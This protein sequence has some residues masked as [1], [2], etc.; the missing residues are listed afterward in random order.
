[1]NHYLIKQSIQGAGRPKIP[2]PEP[3]PPAE[4]QP[5]KLGKMQSLAS[6]SYAETI[7]LVSDGP[8]EGLVNQNGQYV[9]GHRIFEAIYFDEVPV[10]KSLDI[11]FTGTNSVTRADYSLTGAATNLYKLWFWPG[12]FNEKSF[13]GV[14]DF[15]ATGNYNTGTFQTGGAYSFVKERSYFTTNSQVNDPYTCL[16]YA[17][18]YFVGNTGNLFACP[19]P[20]LRESQFEITWTRNDIAK[21]IYRSIDTINEVAARASTYGS[22]ASITAKAKQLRYNFESWVDVKD[23]LLP[24]YIDS[25]ENDYPIFAVK[26][27]LGEPYDDTI[28]G[29]CGTAIIK[30][31]SNPKDITVSSDFTVDEFT[32]SVLIDDI[33]NQVFQKIEIEDISTAR[34]LR[35]LSYLDLT[36]VTKTSSTNLQ[37]AGS[38]IVF[39]FKRDGVSPTQESIQAIKDFVSQVSVINF[40][41][42]KYNYNNVLAEFRDGGELQAPLSYFDK[43]YLSK[44]ISTKLVGPFDVS[45]NVFRISKFDDDTGFNIGESYEFPLQ[46]AQANEGSTDIRTNKNFSSYAGNGKTSFVE[47]AI[48]ITHFVENPNVDRVVVTIGVRGLSDTVQIDSS[49]AGLGSVQAGTKVPS[50]VRFKL[51][52]GLQDSSGKDVTSSVEERIYQIVGLAD[53]PLLVDIGRAE[54]SSII[55]KYKFLAATKSNT[56]IDASTPIVLPTSTNGQRRF[57]RLT[58]TTY[59][60]SSVLMRREISLEKVTEIISSAFSYPTSAI[61][62]TK[63]DSRNISQIPPRSF[64]LRL[65]RV[66]VPSNYYPLRPDGRDKRRYRTLDD[67]NQASA[68]DLLIYKGNWDGT[69]KEAW[70]DNPAWVLFD[71]LIDTEY[72]LG[73]FVS[74]EQVNIWELYKI[75]RF[76]DAVDANGVFVGVPNQFGGKEPRYSINIILGDKVDVYQTINS[77]ANAFRGNIFYSNSEINF[78]DDR[79]KLPVYEFS[80]TNVKEGTFTYTNARR[81]QEYNVVE[82]AYLDENDD[83]KAKVEYVE[84]PE[85]IRQRGVLRTNIDSFGITSKTSANRIGQ[86]ILQ[87]TTNE[88]ESVDFVAGMEAMFVRPGELISINDELKTQQRNFGRVLGV[89]PDIQRVYIDEKFAPATQFKEITLVAP[90]GKK[91]FSEYEGIARYSGGLSFKDIYS[92]DV[93]QIQTF[94]VTGYDNSIDYGSYLYIGPQVEYDF[95]T[96]TGISQTGAAGVRNGFYSGVGT[97]N[98]YKFYSG[99]GEATGY[100]LTRSGTHWYL[101]S[102]SNSGIVTSGSSGLSLPTGIWATG[103]CYLSPQYDNKN[104]DFLD[105]VEQ[106][107]PYSITISGLEKEI[108]KVVSIR[109]V[110]PNEFEV[111]GIKFNSGK[112]AKIESAQNLDDFYAAFDFIQRPRSSPTPASTVYQLDTPNITTFETGDYNN[113]GIIDLTGVW[114]LVDGADSYQVV[115]TRPNGSKINATITGVEYGFLDQTQYGFYRLSVTAKNS[116]LGQISKTATATLNLVTTENLSTPYIRNISIN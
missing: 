60:S 95:V 86:H 18:N 49:P 36:Y 21:S 68:D 83:F 66:L 43:V 48:P 65:K 106:G 33:A 17:P 59:E 12:S 69:F 16:V 94:K 108:Y 103:G 93:P 15:A 100:G 64:D 3:P 107:S 82:V 27:T 47:E 29:E 5:P 8:I 109:E 81:D 41:N 45:K 70:T 74:P 91:S 71:L 85:S 77:V 50:V 13:T 96:F 92:Q 7:D 58:R 2:A 11:N 67:F 99:V 46:G 23:S 116:S 37:L 115:L 80:N 22:G 79:L 42:E 56:A 20:Y 61:I 89:E 34:K 19:D 105:R 1:M 10:K 57:V 31:E 6:Y 53:T 54:N 14:S 75:G 112:F 55:S 113:N 26:F 28:N 25:D 38:I 32:N 111:A 72:G 78:S 9:Q 24:Y 73:N 90:T 98:S 114:P 35:P 51:E 4:L 84:D 52:V 62:G 44:E 87:S 88:N 76:C 30:I 104:L 101:R 40:T 110:S 102:N 97:F 39:G 63:I